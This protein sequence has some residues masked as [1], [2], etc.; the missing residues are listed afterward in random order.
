[1]AEKIGFAYVVFRLGGEEYALPVTA[2]NSIIRYED[3]T[4]VPR[5]PQGV[6]GVINLRG[7]VMPVVDLRHRFSG[8]PFEPGPMSRIVVAEGAAGPVGVAVDS[9][10]E[11][12]EF[13]PEALKPVPEGVLSPETARAFSG[14]VERGGSLVIVLDLDEA[15]PSATYSGA[16]PAD[17]GGLSDV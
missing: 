8:T 3:A 7:R 13:A 6:L 17:D 1:M 16:I 4:P 11:V 15:V 9:A 12:T 10:N 5:A 2:V 14:V